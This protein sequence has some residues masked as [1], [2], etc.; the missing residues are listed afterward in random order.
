MIDYRHFQGRDLPVQ[1]VLRKYPWLPFHF[2]D[3]LLKLAKTEEKE[4]L[5]VGSVTQLEGGRL[6]LSFL[7]QTGFKVAQNRRDSLFCGFEV[8]WIDELV[9]CHKMAQVYTLLKPPSLLSQAAI[10]V[11]NQHRYHQISTNCHRFFKDKDGV[12]VCLAL[13][14]CTSC[15]A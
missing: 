13:S 11:V 8:H 15:L 10:E 6:P 9:R 3:E 7:R 2:S 5:D 1:P 14:F 4:P 12:W